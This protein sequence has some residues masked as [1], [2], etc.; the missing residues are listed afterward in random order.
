ME[1][2]RKTLF[3]IVIA[4]ALAASAET[5][6]CIVSGSTARPLPGTTTVS[7]GLLGRSLDAVTRTT[8]SGVLSGRLDR[9]P[10]SKGLWIFLR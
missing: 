3:T 1:T 6:T 9:R 2:M 4:M 5:A 10:P 7:D 8:C